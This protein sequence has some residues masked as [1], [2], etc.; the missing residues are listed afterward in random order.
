MFSGSSYIICKVSST[1]MVL[2]LK[3]TLCILCLRRWGF[4]ATP[5]FICN[6]SKGDLYIDVSITELF[7]ICLLVCQALGEGILV[8]MSLLVCE[9]EVEGMGGGGRGIVQTSGK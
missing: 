6:I 1:N 8:Q 5:V 3:N 4:H 9:G 2:H 7:W